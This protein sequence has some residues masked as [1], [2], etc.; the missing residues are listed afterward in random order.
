MTDKTLKLQER[1]KF[2]DNGR[3][4]KDVYH[5]EIE[6]MIK[7]SDLYIHKTD[8]SRAA[9]M[10]GRLPNGDRNMIMLSDFYILKTY[11]SRAV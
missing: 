4:R 5:M 11:T 2:Q 7:L 10:E 1:L 8:T 3:R 9:Q 6:D